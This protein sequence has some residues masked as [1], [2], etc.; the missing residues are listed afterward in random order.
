MICK[1]VSDEITPGIVFTLPLSHSTMTMDSLDIAGSAQQEFVTDSNEA[2]ELKL[3]R[4][5]EDLECD[6]ASFAPEMSHQVFGDTETIFGY[7]GL[8]VKLY[9]SAARL[10]TYLG[11]TYE[12]KI[13]PKKSQGVEPDEVLK[14]VA[15]KLP[16]KFFT[17][18]DEFVK[19]LDKDASFRPFGELHHTFSPNST[20]DSDASRTFEIYYCT[21]QTPGLREYHQALQTFILWYI[22]AASY[23][24]VD[25]DR[26]RFFL[27]FERY[28][29]AEGETR[30]AIAGYTTVYEYYAYPC[31]VRPRISQMLVLPPFQKM[32]LGAE[33]LDAVYRHYIPDTR[34]I[35]ITVEDPSDNFTR[36]RD[37]VD[38]RNCAKLAAFQP[39]KLMQGF[40]P[41]MAEEAKKCLKL[42]SKQVRRVYEILRLKATNVSD[43]EEYRNFRL[44][45]KRRLYT[46]YQK[47][48]SDMKK[49]LK[50]LRPEE[51]ALSVTSREQR[52]ETLDRLYTQLEE[53][54]KHVLERL[55]HL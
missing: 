5:R 7:K 50:V 54:Y 49:L 2:L 6:D 3:V 48:D 52:L 44:D 39:K 31:N 33:M 42:N 10:A 34:V 36:L 1:K 22:D 30:Y 27:C 16:P 55:A 43:K 29:S 11:M 24:D 20:S 40:V 19:A 14:P 4:C 45:V 37:F 28:S 41:E 23:I 46:P 53:E 8:R 26:W 47:E 17:N 25:D 32:G 13:D 12:T 51:L 21:A 18:I 15:D 35:D 38:C 9:Y